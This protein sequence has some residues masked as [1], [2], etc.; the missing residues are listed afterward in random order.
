MEGTFRSLEFYSDNLFDFHHLRSSAPLGKSK[1]IYTVEMPLTKL[2]IELQNQILVYWSI[3]NRLIPWYDIPPGICVALKSPHAIANELSLKFTFSFSP[4]LGVWT[5]VCK[6]TS[7]TGC[8]AQLLFEKYIIMKYAQWLIDW[9][10][11]WLIDVMLEY[12]THNQSVFWR[13]WGWNHV[14]SLIGPQLWIPSKMHRAPTKSFL[15]ENMLC[16]HVLFTTNIITSRMHDWSTH[17]WIEAISTWICKR[18]MQVIQ[19]KK[20]R[21]EPTKSFSSASTGNWSAKF[22]NICSKKSAL[23]PIST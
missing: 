21:H 15:A 18:P 22:A 9:L 4:C 1:D 5:R 23:S 13:D 16:E 2:S 14:E 3:S 7:R 6:N 10:N 11:H 17:A 20:N 8:T 19:K 12:D